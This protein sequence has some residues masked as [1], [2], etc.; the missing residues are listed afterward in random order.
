V[1]TLANALDV[2]SS[3]GFDANLL[4]GGDG[5]NGTCTTGPVSA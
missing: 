4:A 3:I 2:R 5:N 1:N